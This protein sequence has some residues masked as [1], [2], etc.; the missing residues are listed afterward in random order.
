MNRNKSGIFFIVLGFI[1]NQWFLAGIA[2]EDGVIESRNI[3]II[4]WC[5]DFILIIIGVLILNK[6]I[7]PISKDGIFFSFTVILVIVIIEVGLS[8]FLYF[9]NDNSDNVWEERNRKKLKRMLL[10]YYRDKEWSNE[11]W[12]EYYSTYE[13]GRTVEYKPYIGWNRK[14]FNGQYVNINTDG[15]RDT[16]H[17]KKNEKEDLPKIFVFGGSTVWGTGVDDNRTIPSELS[18]IFIENNDPHIV[19]NFGESGYS[20]TNNIMELIVNLKNGN[21]PDKAI[22]YNGS[23]LVHQTYNEGDP[24]INPFMKTFAARMNYGNYHKSS[25]D[26]FRLAIHKIIFNHSKIVKILDNFLKNEKSESYDPSPIP[27]ESFTKITSNRIIDYYTDC[28]VLLDNIAKGYGFEIIFIWQPTIFTESLVFDI[29]KSFDQLSHNE[30]LSDIFILCNQKLSSLKLK[31]F[32]N[33][34]NV[35]YNKTEPIFIDF[36]HI[37]GDGNRI[38]AEKIYSILLD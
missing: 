38:I 30:Q 8:V 16:W 21:I 29:E 14:E 10:P 37:T 13:D 11:F 28:L 33:M 6:K 5:I 19:Y 17:P 24:K 4:I 22:F 27:N 34:T 20:I 35:F 26:H 32:Y 9:K 2:S 7:P 15:M 31:N 36:T 23:N 3:K 1:L 18:K 12:N 25:L